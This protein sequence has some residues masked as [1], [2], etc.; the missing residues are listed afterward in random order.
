MRDATHKHDFRE[1]QIIFE[2]DDI[3]VVNK[4]VGQLSQENEAREETLTQSI[5]RLYL[6]NPAAFLEPA[7]RLDR[8]TTG[9]IFFAKHQKALERSVIQWR[10]R[11]VNK[12]YWTLSRFPPEQKSGVLEHYLLRNKEK[13]RTE[14]VASS[15]KEAK[16]ARLSYRLIAEI[17]GLYL[18]EVDLDTGRHHQIRVQL[19]KIGCPVFGDLRYGIPPN[20]QDASICLHSRFLKLRH[21]MKEHIMEFVAPLPEYFLWDAFRDME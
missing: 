13:N 21:P 6:R 15:V 10:D 1:K 20:N 14:A 3:L 17:P 18:L 8:P 11:L 19:A 4:R 12:K 5:R 16:F 9:I 2:D 7:H